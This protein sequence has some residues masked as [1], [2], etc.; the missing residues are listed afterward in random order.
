M[1]WQTALPP[2][3]LKE[4]STQYVQNIEPSWADELMLDLGA[5]RKAR[6][7]YLFH[8]YQHSKNI[9]REPPRGLL[10]HCGVLGHH[11]RAWADGH[12]RAGF[13]SEAK[14]WRDAPLL[15]TIGSIL[16]TVNYLSYNCCGELFA[17][18]GSFIAYNGSWF[19]L[20]W[21]LFHSQSKPSC[22]RLKP[23]CLRWKSASKHLNQF[24]DPVPGL[25]HPTWSW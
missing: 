11:E 4:K 23:S 8:C 7:W 9:S 16:L 12:Q 13:W 18:G 25:S 10:S 14:L 3:K 21:E 22:L 24:V 2:K 5:Q 1:I 20:Q 6:H 17:Y 15:L 19:C